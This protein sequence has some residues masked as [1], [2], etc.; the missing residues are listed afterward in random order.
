MLY[1]QR[2]RPDYKIECFYTTGTQKKIDCLK[3]DGFCSLCYSVFEAMG[4]R[5]QFFPCQEA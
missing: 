1:F 3:V 4:Y 2:Q 5:Y